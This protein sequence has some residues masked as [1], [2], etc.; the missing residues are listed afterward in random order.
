MSEPQPPPAGQDSASTAGT[1]PGGAV[2]PSDDELLDAL[3]DA[4]AAAHE[5]PRNAIS[6]VRAAERFF[7][8][9]YHQKAIGIARVAVAIDPGLAH[10]QH[11][12]SAMLASTGD[13][14]GAID[15]GLA[16]VECA[17]ADVA[18]RQHV[19]GLLA[20]CER[21]RE[22]AQHLSVCVRIDER[23]GDAWNLF[24]SV[25]HQLGRSK[26][27]LEAV[28]RAIALDPG[29]VSY[30]L[31]R[32]S[33][34]AAAGRYSEAM[35]ELQAA[36]IAAPG[37]GA[38]ARMLS[39]LHQHIGDADQALVKAAEAVRHD[40]AN[41][42]Y[43]RHLRQ[44]EGLTGFGDPHAAGDDAWTAPAARGEW[45][46]QKSVR[47]R[48]DRPSLREAW[49]T[50][51][52]V[53]MALVIRETRT[54]Y[55]EARIG[56]AWALIE[57]IMH[58]ALLGTVFSI[59]NGHG[60]S[61]V[62]D[63][64]YLYYVTGLIPYLIFSHASAYT[65]HSIV[66][67]APLLQLPAVT[68]FDLYAARALLEFATEIVVAVVILAA[69]ATLGFQGFPDNLPFAFAG[70]VCLWLV[71][72]GVGCTNAVLS[73]FYKSLEPLYGYFIRILYFASGIYYSPLQMPDWVRDILVW[74][75]VLQGVEWFRSGFYFGYQPHWLEIDYLM[76]WALGALLVGFSLERVLR[77][78]LVLPT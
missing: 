62:G 13:F 6:L 33:L 44:L 64:L 72:V 40:P 78:R 38:V 58:I 17:P 11:A 59:L 39:A 56:Y 24:A 46:R 42:E 60:R 61:P 52:R 3:K 76:Y 53:I 23:R 47:R 66:G 15:A 9:G 57:P 75:P 12:L 16:A 36:E 8:A 48:P 5:D 68:T 26:S 7:Q 28:E 35:R 54:R 37:N 25:L 70:I 65:I 73:V 19:A 30:R 32:A 20:H 77:R 10:G 67:N 74:N 18:I 1:S 49:R 50:Q 4:E 45:S 55:G 41:E 27:A 43:R 2:G 69:F 29:N 71:G 21:W 63:N 51:A 31:A 22:A 14:D 34:V